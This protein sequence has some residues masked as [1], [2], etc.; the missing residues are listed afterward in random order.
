MQGESKGE[1]DIGDDDKEET[2]NGDQKQKAYKRRCPQ[3]TN[4]V[5]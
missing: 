2:G 5:N 3:K 4:D 1:E